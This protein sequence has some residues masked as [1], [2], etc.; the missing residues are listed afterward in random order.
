Q[1]PIYG[2]NR[3]DFDS[4]NDNPDADARYGSRTF[5]HNSSGGAY[6]DPGADACAPLA[7]LF[8]GTTIYDARPGR[9]NY[10]GSSYEPGYSSI[11]NKER[12]ASGYAN[13]NSAFNDSTDLYAT[14]LVNRT[15]DQS[16]SGSRFWYSSLD[17]SGYIFNNL[18]GDLE[19]YQRI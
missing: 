19:S 14:L 9:G 3:K 12:S 4:T 18:S 6:I 2:F 11:L 8:N 17:T 15:K 1:D 10:C 13:L 16:N 7:G 5:V